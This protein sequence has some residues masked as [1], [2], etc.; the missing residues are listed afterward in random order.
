VG[1]VLGHRAPA[2]GLSGSPEKG[3]VVHVADSVAGAVYIGP[4]YP[5]QGLEESP[6]VL[7][8][9]PGRTGERRKVLDRYR[10][11]VRSHPVLLSRL[12]ELR[13]KPLAC[14]CRHDGDRRPGAPACHG[15]VLIEL[16]DRYTDDELRAMD[17][18]A[19]PGG[20]AVAEDVQ[21]QAEREQL[22]AQALIAAHLVGRL[23]ELNAGTVRSRALSVAITEL[24]TGC[25]WLE[26]ALRE[27]PDGGAVQ[28]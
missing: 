19:G 15:D 4:R 7:P 28:P 8:I 16:L 13:G 14:W 23:Q 2:A 11:H 27:A 9:L 6:F 1:T 20:N 24:E 18:V 22:R 3:R 5:R 10:E 25:L 21:R 17:K 12:P 26:K